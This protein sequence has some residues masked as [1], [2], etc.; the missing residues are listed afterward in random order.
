MADYSF[1]IITT[2]SVS[3]IAL[4]GLGIA[5]YR[6]MKSTEREAASLRRRRKEE[7]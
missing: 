4:L 7:S 5:S 2:Y 3:G 1:Y 6:K